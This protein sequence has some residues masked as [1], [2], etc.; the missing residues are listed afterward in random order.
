MKIKF[1]YLLTFSFLLYLSNW[2]QTVQPDG[3]TMEQT[4]EFLNNKL[5]KD[6]KLELAHKNMQLIINFYKNSVLYKIDRVFLGTLDTAKV[7]FS[8]EEKSLILRCRNADEL[9]GK[10]KKF[11]DGCI[12]REIIDKNLIGNYGRTSI[13]AG[14]EKKKI[15]SLQK[16]F[17]HLAKLAQDEEYS[18]N[19]PFE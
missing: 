8:N 12:E 3:I 2:A 5:G 7:S 10:F 19:I 13:E 6:F 1:F 18:S 15:A 11:K 9:E 17:V 14:T 16:A 4:I